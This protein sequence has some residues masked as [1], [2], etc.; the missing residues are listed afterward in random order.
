LHVVDFTKPY[1][2]Y[3]FSLSTDPGGHQGD[4]RAQAENREGVRYC[5]ILLIF[6]NLNGL[7]HETEDG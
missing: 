4:A 5:A 7:S 1:Y 3:K 6:E 2:I